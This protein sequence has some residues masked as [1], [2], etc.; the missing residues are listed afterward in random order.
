MVSTNV[1]PRAIDCWQVTEGVVRS[2]S[3]KVT[4]GCERL[5]CMLIVSYR[6]LQSGSRY[7]ISL[8]FG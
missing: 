6:T 7:V 4:Q 3:L 2:P 5:Y 8:H 1:K